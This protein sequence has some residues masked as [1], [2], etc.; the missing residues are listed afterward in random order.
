M[1]LLSVE[2]NQ[3][4]N[5]GSAQ[6][7][8]ERTEG[9]KKRR[10]GNLLS[11]WTRL[12]DLFYRFAFCLLLLSIYVVVVVVELMLLFSACCRVSVVVVVVAVFALR[13]RL[14]LLPLICLPL[15]F[16]H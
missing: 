6:S 5:V 13:L 15:L 8:R 3:G 16:A 2:I 14:R 1:N 9:R 7:R 10:V 12:R 4:G 11:F